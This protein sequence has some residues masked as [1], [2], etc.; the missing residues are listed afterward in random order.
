MASGSHEGVEIQPAELKF[1]FH[2]NKQLLQAI[3]IHNTTE[4]RI[5]FKIKTTAPKRYVVRPST[6]TVDLQ[7]S[8][9]VQV[10]MGAQK[11][12]GEDLEDCKDKF[13]VQTV[14][15]KEG[16]EIGPDTF[17]KELKKTAMREARL[18]VV[19]EGP[20]VVSTDLHSL[21]E[22]EEEP[23]NEKDLK[24]LEFKNLKTAE[25][26]QKIQEV[27]KELADAKKENKKL[28]TALESLEAERDSIRRTLD[29]VQLQQGQKQPDA[30]TTLK[31]RV[32]MIH[33]VIIAILAFLIGHYS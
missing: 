11:E 22:E 27:S 13:M 24:A 15:L 1:R 19:V 3:N 20:Q 31:F 16:E 2:A 23:L 9:S 33:M 6:G 30:N 4:C 29:M 12:F 17:N 32:S 10:I 18:R 25:Q 5:A 14:L 8:I 21:Q 26:L 28:V 7:A